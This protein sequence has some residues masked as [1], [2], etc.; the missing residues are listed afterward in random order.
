MKKL[1]AA[2][3]CLLVA[4]LWGCGQAVPEATTTATT[5]EA[6]T[7][8]LPTTTATPSTVDIKTSKSDL[9]S[10]VVKAYYEYE[11]S[12]FTKTDA[13]LVTGFKV[14][15]YGCFT[16]DLNTKLTLPSDS[17]LFYSLFDIDKDGTKELLLGVTMNERQT[18]TVFDIYTIQ[19]GIAA[20]LLQ[21]N[22][23]W[24]SAIGIWKNGTVM[25]S[26]MARD[27]PWNRSIWEDYYQF[28]DKN[29][30]FVV[31]VEDWLSREAGT[32]GF[33]K[34]TS[35]END[36]VEISEEEYERIKK[37][38]TDSQAVELPWIPL[39]DYS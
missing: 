24:N 22:A 9:Y 18:P 34:R 15:P 32:A 37:Q 13:E 23:P 31:G 8:E 3:L 16:T 28:V 26:Y 36:P 21:D 14:L 35:S 10:Y 5:T 29:L 2:L 33:C 4:G 12:G 20:Q 7:T 19:D 6:T 39:C 38:Y 17:T 27:N 30:Q 1:C 25:R 11:L